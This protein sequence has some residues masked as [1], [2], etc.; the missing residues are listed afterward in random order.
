MRLCSRV[1]Q[2]RRRHP[3]EQPPRP[4]ARPPR[5]AAVLEQST[6]GVPHSALPL[7]GTGLMLVVFIAGA[8][9][10]WTARVVPALLQWLHR[11]R[12]AAAA[13]RARVGGG[14]GSKAAVRS[15]MKAARSPARRPT[16]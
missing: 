3:A 11:G 10:W 12:K 5:P 15:P 8:M 2:L 9:P 7:L 6:L 13:V 14:D 16:R 1:L 4:A